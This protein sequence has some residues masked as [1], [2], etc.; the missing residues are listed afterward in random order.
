MNIDPFQQ[1]GESLYKHTFDSSIRGDIIVGPWKLIT[2][3]V[4][5]RLSFLRCRHTVAI[6]AATLLRVVVVR[7]SHVVGRGSFYSRTS[8]Q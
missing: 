7:G 3:D 2:G 8:L 5:I 1:E 4:S 6:S